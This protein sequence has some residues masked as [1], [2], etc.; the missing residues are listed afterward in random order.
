MLCG[1]SVILASSLALVLP[2][3]TLPPTAHLSRDRDEYQAEVQRRENRPNLAER[4]PEGFAAMREHWNA[5]HAGGGECDNDVLEQLAAE[6]WTDHGE[7]ELNEANQHYLV[8]AVTIAMR[9]CPDVPA[10]TR[11]AVADRFLEYLRQGGGRDSPTLQAYLGV[12]LNMLAPDDAATQQVTRELL[13]DA[14][15]WAISVDAHPIIRD[16]VLLNG[17]LVLGESFWLAARMP[18]D[19]KM[20]ERCRRIASRIAALLELPED[21]PDRLVGEIRNATSAAL[22]GCNDRAAG[23]SLLARLLLVYRVLLERKPEIPERAAAF[24]DEALLRL[25]RQEG[26]RLT[27]QHWSLW[28]EAV[29][30]LGVARIS[31]GMQ[32]YI[33]VTLDESDLSSAQRAAVEDLRQLIPE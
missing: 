15:Q 20:S 6:L 27:D 10:A 4:F 32:R 26:R 24:L 8:Q 9:R 17:A 13:E 23:E 1:L 30:A 7:P 12:M 14:A 28:R 33:R 21:R 19:E 31:D 22:D 18:D 2:V 3:D 16:D 29:R 5:V 11:R 25:A